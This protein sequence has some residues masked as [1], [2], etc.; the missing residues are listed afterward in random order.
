MINKIIIE[1]T[2][3]FFTS[4]FLPIASA[5]LDPNNPIPIPNPN[6]EY[7]II[8]PIED[9]IDAIVV[10]TISPY[11]SHYSKIDYIIISIKS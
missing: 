2:I 5:I 11:L 3:S 10:S 1:L 4:G 7:P 8:Y 6:S 9:I